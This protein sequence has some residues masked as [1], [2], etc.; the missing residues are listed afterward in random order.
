MNK[1]KTKIIASALALALSLSLSLTACGEAGE[2]TSA[3]GI[4][5]TT[6]A[7]SI[8]GELEQTAFNLGYM[9]NATAHLLAYIAKEEGY[10]AEEG[11]NVTL[12]PLASAGELSAGLESGK[13]DTALIG[14]VPT[15][16]FQSQGHDL[17][18]FGGAMSNGHGYVVKPEFVEG[19]S[20]DEIDITVLKGRTVASVKN[21]IQ[22]VELQTLLKDANLEIG[23]GEDQVDVVY[24][25][26][27]KDAYAALQGAEIDA[28]S[29]FPPY[30]SLAKEA[31]YKVIFYCNEVEQ[32]KNQPCC[33][34]VAV[35][36]ALEEKP[37]TYLVFERAFIK[38]YKFSQENQERSIQDIK[39][40]V[41]VDEAYLKFEVY[42]GHAFSIPD[43]DKTATL[44]L[45]DKIVELGY[46]TDFDAEK[47]YNTDIY[48]KAL[49]S[50]LTENPDDGIYQDL[51]EHFEQYA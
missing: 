44:A 36:S 46:T 50:L 12:V 41:D 51:Q 40:Y 23:K 32:F 20:D 10:F 22:D 30:S 4:V 2:S 1:N 48:E 26:S 42:G 37:N 16:T 14:S 17:T 9:P 45:K 31:G 28:S 18:I 33:R 11:L 29:I 34:Q 7:A 49:N 25:D 38:A 27:Q 24:F 21:S 47:L 19:L 3:N 43:P 15:L 8:T 5:S 39:K 6:S 35:S 13:L